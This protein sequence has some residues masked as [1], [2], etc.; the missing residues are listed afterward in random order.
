MSAP[1][2]AKAFLAICRAFLAT[3]RQGREEQGSPVWA[4]DSN[5]VTWHQKCTRNRLPDHSLAGYAA[6]MARAPSTWERR[7]TRRRLARGARRLRPKARAPHAQPRIGA[8]GGSQ[9]W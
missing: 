4:S 7:L 9:G 8:F 3:A 5:S 1:A 6:R 2:R